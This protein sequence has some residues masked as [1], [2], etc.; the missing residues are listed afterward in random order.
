MSLVIDRKKLAEVGFF[1]IRSRPARTRS[2]PGIP[3]SSALPNDGRPDVNAAKAR[4]AETR[5]PNG[6]AF[7]M[8]VPARPQWADQVVAADLA[9]IGVTAT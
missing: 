1:G 6:F 4:L 9:K 8:I 5:W 7:E 3:T 2:S